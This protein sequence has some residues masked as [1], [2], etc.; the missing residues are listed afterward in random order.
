MT[1]LTWVEFFCSTKLLSFFFHCYFPE[2]IGRDI[3][4]GHKDSS[5]AFPPDKTMTFLDP[6]IMTVFSYVRYL[7]GLNRDS[8]LKL[9]TLKACDA[10]F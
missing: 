2:F 10:S 8:L 5:L 4:H 6:Y 9:F 7:N 3:S 1:A